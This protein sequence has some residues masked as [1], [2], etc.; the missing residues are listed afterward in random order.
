MFKKAF[1]GKKQ[2]LI[3]AVIVLVVVVMGIIMALS[4]PQKAKEES[5]EATVHPTQV[6]PITDAN[7]ERTTKG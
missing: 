7:C 1:K 6:Q 5:K 3:L 2:R 4:K